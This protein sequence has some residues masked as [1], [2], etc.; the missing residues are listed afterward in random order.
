MGYI[1][2]Y[3]MRVEEVEARLEDWLLGEIVRESA[4]KME[5][6]LYKYDPG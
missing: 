4:A 6:I 3:G 1:T 5:Q 2:F